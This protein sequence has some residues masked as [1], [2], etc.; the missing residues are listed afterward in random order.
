M[1]RA[2]MQGGF[3]PFQS[4]MVWIDGIADGTIGHSS[5]TIGIFDSRL[6]IVDI[7]HSIEDT[8]NINARLDSVTAKTFDDIVR[9]RI[10][11]EQ[12]TPTA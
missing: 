7:V 2:A 6:H 8:H 1:Q 5:I 3:Y 4:G 11:A 10:V 12:V 9:I